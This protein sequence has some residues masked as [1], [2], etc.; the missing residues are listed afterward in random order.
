M[1]CDHT[2]SCEQFRQPTVKEPQHESRAVDAIGIGVKKQNNTLKLARIHI[3]GA[4]PKFNA[5]GV[6]E[7][8]EEGV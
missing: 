8:L 3:A 4:S 5:E 1:S 6:C 7:L 2:A